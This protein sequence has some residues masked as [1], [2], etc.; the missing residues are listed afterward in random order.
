MLRKMSAAA[1]TVVAAAVVAAVAA[2]GRLAGQRRCPSVRRMKP[3]IYV[4][5]GLGLILVVAAV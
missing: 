2:I 1:A 4:R 3:V 5:C